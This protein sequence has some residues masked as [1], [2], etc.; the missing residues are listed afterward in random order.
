MARLS[1]ELEGGSGRHSGEVAQRRK[2]EA[3]RRAGILGQDVVNGQ[4]WAYLAGDTS[5]FA[6]SLGLQA[7]PHDPDVASREMAA[8]WG[9][10]QIWVGGVNLCAHREEGETI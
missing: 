3:E 8:S 1:C 10:F 2:G 4:T 6:I 5:R 9:T 7:N